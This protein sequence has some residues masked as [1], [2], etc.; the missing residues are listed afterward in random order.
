MAAFTESLI[1]LI[2]SILE[3]PNLANKEALNAHIVEH[4]SKLIAKYKASITLSVALHRK[5]T[6]PTESSLDEE[7]EMVL[8]NVADMVSSV[9]CIIKNPHHKLN[10]AAINLETLIDR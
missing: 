10:V 6:E 7:S 1:N 4:L 2:I 8:N 3:N 9:F 5:P